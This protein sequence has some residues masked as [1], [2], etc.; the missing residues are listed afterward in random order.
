MNINLHH[1]LVS[2]GALSA[3]RPTALAS[4]VDA[5]WCNVPSTWHL[6][7]WKN[8]ALYNVPSTWH[9]TIWKKGRVSSKSDIKLFESYNNLNT[10]LSRSAALSAHLT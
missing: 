8:E 2:T 6:T 5:H 7:V 4:S 1:V 9:L 10:T 3:L